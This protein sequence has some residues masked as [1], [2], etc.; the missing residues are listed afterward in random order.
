MLRVISE[1]KPRW[2]I[3]ENVGGLVNMAQPDGKPDLE[4]ETD[5]DA[6]T[7][8]ELSADGILFGII[9]SLENL[10][11]S[12]Q[13]FVIPACA[14]EAPHRR[15]RIWIVANSGCQHGTGATDGRELKRQIPS[16]EDAVMPER[17]ACNDGQ[18]DDTDTE[19]Q[20]L[21]VGKKTHEARLSG[22]ERVNSHASD[23][24]GKPADV[25]GH[26]TSEIFWER[27]KTPRIQGRKVNSDPEKPGLERGIAEGNG[28]TGGCAPEYT[29]DTPW[30]EVATEL[31]RVDDGLPVE[32]GKFKLSK[33][34]HREEQLKGYGNAIVPII[35]YIIM[36][37]IQEIE[38]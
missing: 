27:G 14:V 34:K 16:Q 28:C 23:T 8:D 1:F 4:S 26:G 36:K 35:P 11:Y 17:S 2:I 5:T 15:D 33:S 13:S 25:R 21:Q 22:V 12:V 9:D 18:G 6:E 19:R 38:Q 37:A 20:R 29:W 3:G 32:L 24:I 30:L 31:C 10:G 7:G